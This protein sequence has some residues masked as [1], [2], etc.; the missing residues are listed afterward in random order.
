[1]SEK[2]VRVAV[3]VIHNA[4]GDIFIARR[5]VDAHQGGL[6]EFPGGKVEEDETT[7]QALVRELREELAIEVQACEPLIQIRH[8]YPDK[9]VLLDV[10]R[11]T[12]F[13]G[14]ARGNEGQPVR[15]VAPEDLT[16]FAFPAANK[17]I[18]AAV[19][20]PSLCAISASWL[21]QPDFLRRAQQA[22]QAGAGMLIVRDNPLDERYISLLSRMAIEPWATNMQVQLNTSPEMFASLHRAYPSAGLH[23]NRHQLRTLYLQGQPRPVPSQ[24]LLGASCHSQ[25]EL[26]WAAQLGV[27]YALL[28]PV[29]ATESHPGAAPL[30][31][32]VFASWVADV[33]FPV[34]A[35]GG[36]TP[37][38]LAQA[39]AAGA[40]GIAALR[41][42]WPSE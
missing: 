30:G 5:A 14:E 4:Q 24:V 37:G 23:L 2:V 29:L 10:Y 21:N 20:L 13:S 15:W 39:K 22:Q 9:S 38:Q 40:Q 17:P 8:H 19:R 33:A 42:F 25:E 12:A 34:Y 41:A 16:Q 1:M 28:S 35:L 36:V 27:D 3:G 6:W 18:I 7:P 11:V 26:Q 32:S 31:W